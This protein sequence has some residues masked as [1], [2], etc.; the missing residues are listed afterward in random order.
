MVCAAPP[1]LCSDIEGSV[2]R[3][4]LW[5][6]EMVSTSTTTLLNSN[7]T[8]PARGGRAIAHLHDG[9]PYECPLHES[10]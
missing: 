6:R 4:L 2:A 7:P 9:F 1:L 5:M 3:K 10:R 8:T